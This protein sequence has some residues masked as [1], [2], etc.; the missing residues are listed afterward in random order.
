MS[1]NEFFFIYLPIYYFTKLK[2]LVGRFMTVSHSATTRINYNDTFR[3]CLSYILTHCNTMKWML[4]YCTQIVWSVFIAFNTIKLCLSK[5]YVEPLK[6]IIIKV[7][8]TYP[9]RIQIKIIQK[10]KL[11]NILR[12]FLLLWNVIWKVLYY[13]R[14]S[15][16]LRLHRCVF[17]LIK[18]FNY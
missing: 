7:Y 3:Y 6:F 2:Y 10:T 13:I 15:R 12:I 1:W 9:S 14:I 8:S 18:Y 16:Y 4:Y 17:N 5:C 11:H